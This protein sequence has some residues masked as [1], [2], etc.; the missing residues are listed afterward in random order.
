MNDEIRPLW[1]LLIL[2]KD[3]KQTVS[4][5]CDECLLLIQ[6]DAD[7]LAAGEADDQVM[8]IINQHIK[9]CST[10]RNKLDDWIEEGSWKKPPFQY[11]QNQTRSKKKYGNE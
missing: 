11:F 10:C 8:S 7:L 2:A 4:I 5:N 1:Q 3:G 6:Y 9:V